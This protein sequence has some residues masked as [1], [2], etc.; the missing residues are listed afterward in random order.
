[1][2]KVERGEV[3]PEVGGDASIYIA[4]DKDPNKMDVN[5]MI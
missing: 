4:L 1:M 5:K 2:N 3:V